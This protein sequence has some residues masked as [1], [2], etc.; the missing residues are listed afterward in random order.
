MLPSGAPACE[1][2]IGRVIVVSRTTLRPRS[3]AWASNALALTRRGQNVA[4]SVCPNGLV[5]AVGWSALFGAHARP[6]AR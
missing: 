2:S 6:L 3:G 1:C 5:A 4:V